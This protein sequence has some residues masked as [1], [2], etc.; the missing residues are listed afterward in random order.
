MNAETW[1]AFLITLYTVSIIPGPSMLLA[2]TH[3]LRFGAK[4]ALATASGN[5]LASTI[6]AAVS[7]A[8]LGAIIAASGTIF[9]AIKYLGAVYLIYLGI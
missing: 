9:F 3:G 1:I 6:Q 7:I 5:M 2:L 8:G 4:A